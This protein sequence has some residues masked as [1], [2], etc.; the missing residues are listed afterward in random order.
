[1][2]SLSMPRK[3]VRGSR[4]LHDICHISCCKCAA[5]TKVRPPCHRIPDPGLVDRRMVRRLAGSM[6]VIA[7]MSGGC[8]GPGAVPALSSGSSARVSF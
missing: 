6:S 1:M 3:S 2:K 5:M 7:Q 4:C 8:C